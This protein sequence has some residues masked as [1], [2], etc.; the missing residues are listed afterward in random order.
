M[1]A[2]IL[3]V[4]ALGLLGQLVSTDVDGAFE[5]HAPPNVGSQ[6]WYCENHAK[7]VWKVPKENLYSESYENIDNYPAFPLENMVRSPGTWWP[8]VM[9]F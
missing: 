9:D 5:S 7:F 2:A 3:Y 8:L 4:V 6:F 1:N